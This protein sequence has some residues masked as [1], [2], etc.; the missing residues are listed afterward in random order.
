[1][2]TRISGALYESA[3]LL[4]Y[5]PIS[6][7]V[8][9]GRLWPVALAMRRWHRS[10][11]PT[12]SDIILAHILSDHVTPLQ[13]SALFRQWQTRSLEMVMQILAM[14]RPGR[15]WRPVVQ[16]KGLDNL[17]AALDA[18]H[19][20]ILWISDFVY[21]PLIVPVALRQAGFAVVH[22]SRPE[23]GFS[24]SPFGVHFLN[25]IWAAAEN[26]FLAQRVVIENNDASGALETLRKRLTDNG[27]VSITVAETGRRTLDAKF[28][29]GRIRVATGPAHLAR[30]S[31]APL[32]PVFAVRSDDGAY[33]VSIGQALDV[34]DNCKPAYVTAIQAYAAMLEPYVLKYADQWN[35]WIALGRLAEKAVDSAAFIGS[36]D[37]PT[38]LQQALDAHLGRRCRRSDDCA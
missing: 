34:D 10:S 18:R 2:R 30:T 11:G 26:R 28:F 38:A 3:K 20:V 36:F 4:T 29:H 12:T 14:H 31:R 1:M 22:L 13:A 21:R 9:T 37:R 25:P 35:G 5:L 6:W 16:V 15:R 17:T 23:H 32:L 27:I 7:L 33:E 8:P 24:V 19:G